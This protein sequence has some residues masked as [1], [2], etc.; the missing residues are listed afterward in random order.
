[1]ISPTTDS[2]CQ[3]TTL[4]R[5]KH[6]CPSGIRARNPSK[7]AAADPRLTAWPLGSALSSIFA[8]FRTRCAKL[9]DII[10]Q[11]F[12]VKNF[13]QHMPLYNQSLCRF[14]NFNSRTWP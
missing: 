14:E 7:R 4:S 6:P 5:D 12:R 2:T 9:Q 3:H 10:F 13:Y 11:S 1:V 8:M